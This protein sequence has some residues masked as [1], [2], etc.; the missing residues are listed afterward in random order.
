M[1]VTRDIYANITDGTLVKST[2]ENTAVRF[3]NPYHQDNLS[4]VIHPVE[5]DTSRT[6][7]QG[8]F[9]EISATGLS[10]KVKIFKADGTTVLASQETFT[11]DGNT[12]VGALNLNTAAMSTAITA[13]AGDITTAIVEFEFTYT[14]S[15]SVTIQQRNLTIYKECITTGSPV[16]IE[17]ETYL[18]EAASRSI[19]VKRV[20]EPGE[21]QYFTSPD[22]TKQVFQWLDNNGVLHTDL[23]S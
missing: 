16:A 11:A 20:G 17:N 23:I 1:A 9:A 2:R 22:G 8:P 7:N 15:T 19:F 4:L 5:I 3:P 14:D 10:L 18:T 21:G 12:L 6:P 13:A